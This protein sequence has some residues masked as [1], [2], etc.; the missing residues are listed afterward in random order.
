[1]RWFVFAVALVSLVG[2][3]RFGPA[4][5]E[6][7]GKITFRGTAV[8]EG[9]VTFF[10]DSIGQ[11][12]EGNLGLDGRYEIKTYEGGLLVGDYVV[13]VTPLR[14]LDSS[15]PKTPPALVEKNA[16]DIP[17][18]YRGNS[19]TPLKATVVEGKNTFDFDLMP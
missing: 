8:K 10:S 7:Q 6:V 19:S 1:M 13:M 18:K 16:P 9:T 5:G 15:D 14:R 2:G 12:G 11:G 17:V 4:R 3:C